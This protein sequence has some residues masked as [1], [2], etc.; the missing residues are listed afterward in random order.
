MAL[1]ADLRILKTILGGSSAHGSHA[2]RMER[3]YAAQADCYDD[4]RRRLLHGRETMIDTLDIPE[5]GTLLDL[6]GGTASNLEALGERIRRLR[7]VTVVDLSPS[8][9]RIANERIRR[10]SWEN[11]AT[12]EADVTTFEPEDGPVD[13]ITFSY[14]LTMIPDWFRAIDQASN[15]L[16]PGGQIGVA[17]FHVL[18]AS[19]WRRHFWPAW[20]GWD[21]VNPSPDHRPYLES[22]FE[23]VHLEEGWG[24]VPYLPA[25]RAPYYVFVGRKP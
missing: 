18:R 7:R 2:E 25:L 3:F 23:T 6:G 1:L 12:I 10:H 21:G 16:K 19:W 13:A 14:S 8:L 15:N 17:D 24:R 22:R 9:L 11:V 20:F 5:D 4:F